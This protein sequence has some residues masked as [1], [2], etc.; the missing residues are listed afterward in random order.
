MRDGAESPME[1]TTLAEL[2]GDDARQMTSHRP[3]SRSHKLLRPWLRPK[4]TSFDAAPRRS[5]Q[6][7]VIRGGADS[8]VTFVTPAPR[9]ITAGTDDSTAV[10][11]MH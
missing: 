11:D 1:G 9:G 10:P 5:V 3:S 8:K 6:R 7:Q 2:R 4:L